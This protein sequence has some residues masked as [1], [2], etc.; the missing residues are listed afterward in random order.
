ML[1]IEAKYPL[2]DPEEMTRRLVA[3][4]AVFHEDR[5]DRDLYFHAPDRDFVRTDEAFRLRRIGEQNFLTYKG[6]KLDRDTKT[7]REIE[8]GFGTGDESAAM[9]MEMLTAL[10]Y[11]PV[12]EVRK[13][14]STAEL[15]HQGTRV[16]LSRDQ[17][18]QVGSFIE[19]E[20]VAEESQYESA[21]K[22]LLDLAG[23]LN[24]GPT[25]RRSYLGMLLESLGRR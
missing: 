21:R 13:R 11:R 22:I 17:V 5:E 9:M 7:R 25:E 10:G 14:R 18:E 3:L 8:V 20:I 4:G 6:P 19:L 23:K 2:P 15:T 1:E 12:I 24:L 16:H